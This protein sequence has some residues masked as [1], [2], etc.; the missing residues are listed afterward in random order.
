MCQIANNQ[1]D[2]A[3]IFCVTRCTFCS[4]TTALQIAAIML[5]KIKVHLFV[6]SQKIL[7]QLQSLEL[8]KSRGGRW[9]RKFLQSFRIL[10]SLMDPSFVYHGWCIGGWG[11]ILIGLMGRNGFAMYGFGGCIG[12]KIFTG[13]MGFIGKPGL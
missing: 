2:L 4:T 13:K 8:G 3:Q 12:F 11:K 5:W 7:F 6:S 1:S 10:S 9:S